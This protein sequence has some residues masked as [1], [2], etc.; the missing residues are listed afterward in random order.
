MHEAEEFPLCLSGMPLQ[1]NLVLLCRY[2]NP[3]R[4]EV[5]VLLKL[6]WLAVDVFAN[7]RDEKNAVRNH[8]LNRKLQI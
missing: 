3:Q 1:D 2:G 6:P 5:S 8:S 7:V 4:T